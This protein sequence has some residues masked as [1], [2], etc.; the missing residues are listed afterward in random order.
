M[1]LL[2]LDPFQRTIKKP[3]S[4]S[5]VGVHSGKQ[6]TI[7]LNPSQA[8]TGVVFKRTDLDVSPIIPAL[9]NQISSTQLST[10]IGKGLYKISTV[11]HL[12]AALFA[13]G[14]DNLLVEIDGPEMPIMD[15]SSKV[16]IKKILDAGTTDLPEEKQFYVLNKPIEVNVGNST[17]KASPS[18]E[19]TYNCSIDFGSKTIGKQKLSLDAQSNLFSSIFDART[20]C[21]LSEWEHLKAAGLGL[22]GSLENAIV[23]DSDNVLNPE[24][25]R[26]KN[27]FVMHKLLDAIGDYYLLGL[28]LVASYDLYKPGH[29]INACFTQ[30]LLENRYEYLS[31][32]S[33]SQLFRKQPVSTPTSEPAFA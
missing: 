10:C 24:G 4:L 25:L 17:I 11:E 12:M 3:I 16:F 2:H 26:F 18:Q 29:A 31:K 7:K 15:G 21:L 9:A 23:V 19:L 14:I 5:G 32:V 27:E 20:F 1:N 28:P 6:A 13:V 30:L 33:Y 22:G 8:N